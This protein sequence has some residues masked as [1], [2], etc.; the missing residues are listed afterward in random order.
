MFVTFVVVLVT[1]VG[2]GLTLPV[3][4][5]RLG[6][7][8]DGREEEQEELAARLHASE[9]ALDELDV[10]VAEGWA[11]DDDVDAVR[12]RYLQRSRRFAARAGKIEDDGYEEASQARQRI[13]HR[14]IA[15]E[16]A[17]IVGLRNAGRISN[18]TMHRLERELDLYETHLGD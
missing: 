4:V 18:E 9:R 5:R 1:V 2:Q 8:D 12:A 10:I 14:V 3:L 17:A 16:R 15:E 13:V 7:L 6:V 11:P